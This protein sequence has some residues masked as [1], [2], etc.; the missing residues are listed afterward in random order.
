MRSTEESFLKSFLLIPADYPNIEGYDAQHNPYKILVE[1]FKDD[2]DM[3]PLMEILT[4]YYA[5]SNTIANNIELLNEAR[6]Y[7]Y[8]PDSPEY[9]ALFSKFLNN[10]PQTLMQCEVG[11]N[12][13][14]QFSELMRTPEGREQKEKINKKL[15]ELGI[16]LTIDSFLITCAQRAPR[17]KLLL[18]EI[19]K[20][21]NRNIQNPAFDNIFEK[22]QSL[23]AETDDALGVVKETITNINKGLPGKAEDKGK[24][25][26]K[27]KSYDLPVNESM[28]QELKEHVGD[29]GARS[30]K[31]E[32]IR[33]FQR[34]SDVLEVARKHA[35]SNSRSMAVVKSKQYECML[36]EMKKKKF[37]MK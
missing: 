3:A 14:H 2:S 8:K 19:M 27:E 22:F 9:L 35:F 24:G 31:H 32:A 23:F 29:T 37:G 17:Y 7:K 26:E 25:K 21:Q 20:I 4:E 36:D 10:L 30:G 12:L 5:I 11:M 18:E 34:S 16:D 1:K 15:M 28:V 13:F 33:E 6:Q